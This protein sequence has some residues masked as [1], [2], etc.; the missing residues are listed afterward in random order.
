[1][2]ISNFFLNKLSPFALFASNQSI[3]NQQ[4]ILVQTLENSLGVQFKVAIVR[5][6]NCAAL[7][8]KV[9]VVLSSRFHLNIH[10][11]LLAYVC[12]GVTISAGFLDTSGVFVCVPSVRDTWAGCLSRLLIQKFIPCKHH[13]IKDFTL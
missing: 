4:K 10:N 11:C 3:Y 1:M 8:I 5:K 9:R 6:A 2:T 7:N 12:S 13:P